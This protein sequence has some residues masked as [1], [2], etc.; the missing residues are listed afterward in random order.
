MEYG[1]DE[2]IIHADCLVQ[3]LAYS[4]PS[5]NELFDEEN[6]ERGER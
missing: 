6:E 1:E 4:K 3:C 5:I 2:E